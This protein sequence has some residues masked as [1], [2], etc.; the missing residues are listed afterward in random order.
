MRSTFCGH[1]YAQRVRVFE[2][3]MALLDCSEKARL[4]SEWLLP[5]SKLTEDRTSTTCIPTRHL[6]RTAAHAAS[7]L[8]SPARTAVSSAA[9][10][11]K[12]LGFLLVPAKLTLIQIDIDGKH[13]PVLIHAAPV[14]CSGQG[15]QVLLGSRQDCVCRQCLSSTSV[16]ILGSVLGLT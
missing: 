1:V 12:Q 6:T 11:A 7:Y 9:S 5:L 2:V 16:S 4:P 10:N 8:H 3:G 14:A 15:Q 13:N